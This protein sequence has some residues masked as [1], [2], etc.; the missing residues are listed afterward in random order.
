[1]KSIKNQA[2]KPH[3]LM[4]KNNPILHGIL[5]DILHDKIAC[6]IRHGFCTLHAVRSTRANAKCQALARRAEIAANFTSV[7]TPQ[8]Y[9]LK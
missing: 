1:M 6:K 3:S 2:S 7:F 9:S 8:N 5:H 4:L